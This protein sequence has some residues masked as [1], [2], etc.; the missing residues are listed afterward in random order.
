MFD[1]EEL[2]TQVDEQKPEVIESLADLLWCIFSSCKR[3]RDSTVGVEGNE[4][5]DEISK[6]ASRFSCIFGQRVYSLRV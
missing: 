5:G 2:V 6:F 1:E 4:R 3:L